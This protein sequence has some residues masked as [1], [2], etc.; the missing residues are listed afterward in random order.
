MVELIKNDSKRTIS[1]VLVFARLSP[2]QKY[3]QYCNQ[4]QQYNQNKKK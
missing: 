2:I 4:Q 1:D 3:Y